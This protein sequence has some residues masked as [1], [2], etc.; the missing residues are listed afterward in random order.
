MTPRLV[1]QDGGGSL[2]P[3]VLAIDIGGG[4]P[5]F[6]NSLSAD[7]PLMGPDAY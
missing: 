6:T 4:F 7:P 5:Y 3:H 2:G 1:G